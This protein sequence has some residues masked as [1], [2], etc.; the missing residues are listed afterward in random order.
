MLAGIARREVA[1]NEPAMAPRLREL[2][3]YR[4]T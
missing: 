4:Q 2:V 1:G 3:G